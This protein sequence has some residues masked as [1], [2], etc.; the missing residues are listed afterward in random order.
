MNYD[1]ITSAT[2]TTV[3]TQIY[4]ILSNVWTASEFPFQ[5]ARLNSFKRTYSVELPVVDTTVGVMGIS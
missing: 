4:L 5:E 3:R 1:S 2:A